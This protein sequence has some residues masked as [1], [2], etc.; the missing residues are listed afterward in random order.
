MVSA[1][2]DARR[3]KYADLPERTF[4]SEKL[5]T[6]NRLESRVK[7]HERRKSIK[8]D[9]PRWSGRSNDIGDDTP[10]TTIDRW[11]DVPHGKDL[12]LSEAWQCP[13]IED[14]R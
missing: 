11:T 9:A 2:L 14:I 8:I 4:K 10:R 12:T 1:Q 7:C 5:M 6:G 3:S 13:E